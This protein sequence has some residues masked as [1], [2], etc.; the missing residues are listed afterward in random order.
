MDLGKSRIVATR[1]G[2]KTAT[3]FKTQRNVKSRILAKFR[4][5]NGLD[6]FCDGSFTRIYWTP[7][8]YT[9][10]QYCVFSQMIFVIKQ[11]CGSHD[12]YIIRIIESKPNAT[13]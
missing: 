4:T 10:I 6:I 13:S 3:F 11:K 7:N 8:K 5:G 1:L 12:Y 9:Q 2:V